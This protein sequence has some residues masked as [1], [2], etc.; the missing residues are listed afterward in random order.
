YSYDASNRGV[1]EREYTGRANV[2]QP[3]TESSNR[4]TAKLRAGDPDYFETKSMYLPEG[5]RSEVRHP[6]GNLTQYVYESDLN[7]SAPR[8]AR[9]NL[10]EVH[11]LPGPL[12]GDQTEI[13][14]K[15][16]YLSGLGSCGCGTDFVTKETDG[17][18][19]ETV[20]D[21]DAHG[22]RTHTHHPGVVTTE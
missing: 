4:P 14:E 13:V 19:K 21:Y 17:R 18:G 11:H 7:P 6:N 9:G 12:G 2:G 10:R 1:M 5:Q 15:F 8:F 16:E 3:T 22:N 20:H